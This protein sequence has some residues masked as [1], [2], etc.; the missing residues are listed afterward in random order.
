MSWLT[1]IWNDEPGG[2]VEHIAANGLTTE[3]VDHALSNPVRHTVSRS[4]G[5]PALYGFT[6]DGRFIFVAYDEI[7]EDTIEPITA[8][9]VRQ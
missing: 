1:V 3:N 5:R 7:D 4:T 2:N 8:Y 9:E 6:Q